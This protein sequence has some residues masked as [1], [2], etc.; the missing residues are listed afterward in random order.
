MAFYRECPDCGC[1]LDPGEKCDC[2]QVKE[3]QR[4][5]MD[6]LFKTD[7]RG[8]LYLNLNIGGEK[9]EKLAM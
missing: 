2:Q 9:R 5:A 8:Q 6:G 1:A 3:Q 7:G 4:K